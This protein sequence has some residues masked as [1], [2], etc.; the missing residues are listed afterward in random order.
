M[1]DFIVCFFKKLNPFVYAF[2]N[3]QICQAFRQVI[4]RRCCTFRRQ[5]NNEQQIDRHPRAYSGSLTTDTPQIIPKRINSF[6]IDRPRTISKTEND[7]L[8]SSLRAPT[9]SGLVVSFAD[10]LNDDVP[11]CDDKQSNSELVSTSTEKNPT[12]T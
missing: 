11:P 6:S 12:P 9:I 2:S 10:C 3:R 8:N 4:F 7:S 1:N 5:S